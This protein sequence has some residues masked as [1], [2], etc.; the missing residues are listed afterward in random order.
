MRPQTGAARNC[1]MEKLAISEAEFE[2]NTENAEEAAM[3]N[4][5]NQVFGR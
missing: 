2:L 3:T 5:L 4:G 1:M